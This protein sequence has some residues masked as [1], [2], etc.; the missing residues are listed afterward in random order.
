[1]PDNLTATR[2]EPQDFLKRFYQQRGIPDDID[3]KY[4]KLLCLVKIPGLEKPTF[5]ELEVQLLKDNGF[6][7]L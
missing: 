3:M 5:A 4:Q 1:M 7:F 6:G 2:E